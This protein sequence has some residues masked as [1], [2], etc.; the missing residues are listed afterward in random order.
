MGAVLRRMPILTRFLVSLIV[1]LAASFA[2]AQI[3]ARAIGVFLI[4]PAHA[5]DGRAREQLARSFALR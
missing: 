5:G 3:G 4:A 2:L 1:V